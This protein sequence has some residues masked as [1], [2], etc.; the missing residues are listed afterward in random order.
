MI[1]VPNINQS[2]IN[3]SGT[4]T[5]QTQTVPA[6]V[7]QQNNTTPN[8][9]ATI[10]P[11]ETVSVYNPDENAPKLT[12]TSWFYINDVHGKMTNMERIYNIS[13][14][15][16]STPANIMASKFFSGDDSVSKFKVSSG[17]IILGEEIIP[18]TVASQFLNWS[19][20]IA[21]ALGNHELDITKPETFAKFLSESNY[22]ML[23]AN[24]DIDPNSPLDR[25]S[26]V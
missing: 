9:T 5:T 2:A 19:G 1:N 10:Y 23:A 17:D 22:K 8:Y 11:Q 15:F 7:S 18:N 13:K 25:K 4:I 26:V 6:N 24:V 3:N 14:E 20:F 12:H 21:S 16:D